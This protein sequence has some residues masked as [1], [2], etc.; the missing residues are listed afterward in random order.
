M[1]NTN[2]KTGRETAFTLIELL[3]VIAIIGILAGLLLPVLATAKKKA[4]GIVCI[5]NLKQ[6]G[7]AMMFYVNDNA[8]VFP[9]SAGWPQDYHPEDWIYWRPAGFATAF[10]P[11]PDFSL[12]PLS[13]LMNT[14]GST[15]L[16]RCPMDLSDQLRN[17]SAAAQGSPA[18]PFSYTFNGT[19]AG[20]GMATIFSGPG[21][22][23]TATYFKLGSVVRASQKIMFAE[24]PGTDAE[25]PPG[26]VHT[27][28]EDGRWLPKAPTATTW[29]GKTVALRHS[30][31]NGNAAFADGH[32]ESIPWQYTTN[33]FYFNPAAN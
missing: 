1:K 7:L 28:L 3:V 14:A 30:K 25:R 9:A 18:F 31:V 17:A 33:T 21:P 27:A 23:A 5:N 24:E 8:D 6:I 4:K 22:A 32:A 13:R 19:G 16:F 11:A 2:R 20:S 15:N 29:N 26:N 12:S 10:G